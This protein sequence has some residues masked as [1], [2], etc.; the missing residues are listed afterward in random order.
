MILR[1]RRPNQ[2]CQSTEGPWMSRANLSS[3]AH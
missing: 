1:I 2:Q 3:S